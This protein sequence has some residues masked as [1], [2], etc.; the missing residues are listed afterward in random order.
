MGEF[1]YLMQYWQIVKHNL[2]ISQRDKGYRLA[3][4][5]LQKMQT[6]SYNG[7]KLFTRCSVNE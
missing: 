4:E 3:G 5:I 6:S 2:E 7:A 1:S